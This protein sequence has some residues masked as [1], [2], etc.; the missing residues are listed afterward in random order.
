MEISGQQKENKKRNWKSS[1][2]WEHGYV[3]RIELPEHADWRKA[4]AYV[5]NDSL[6]EIK[7]PKLAKDSDAPQEN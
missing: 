1:Q 3:R 2:W 7:I 6:L 5:K 4:E